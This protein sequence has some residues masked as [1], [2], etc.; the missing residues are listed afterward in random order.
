MKRK[1]TVSH[2]SQ[3]IHS[4]SAE[5]CCRLRPVVSKNLIHTACLRL[6]NATNA[7]SDFSHKSFPFAEYV[8]WERSLHTDLICWLYSDHK[9]FLKCDLATFAALEHNAP[10]YKDII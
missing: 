1:A 2:I 9:H 3:T 4:S 8:Q 10:S 7:L 5:N 6:C